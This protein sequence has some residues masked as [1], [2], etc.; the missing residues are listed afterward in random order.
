MMTGVAA[1]I[2]ALVFLAVV[3]L[4]QRMELRADKHMLDAALT[5]LSD[6]INAKGK[7]SDIKEIYSA[8]PNVSFAVYDK[9]GN[10]LQEV[11]RLPLQPRT[12]FGLVSQNRAYFASSGL[13]A[14]DYLIVG[15]V[16]WKLT[17][18]RL[19]RFSLILLFLWFF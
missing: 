13:K 11:G 12:E 16:D 7:V 4:S 19:H 14:K 6:N 10:K 15:A 5:Q 9:D 17:Q 18:S 2:L 8:Y 3:G 1:T